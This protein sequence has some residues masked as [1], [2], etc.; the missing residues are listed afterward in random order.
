[1]TSEAITLE[2][3]V[4]RSEGLVSADVGDEVVMLHL[5]KNAYYDTDPV[6]AYIWRRLTEP[7][8]VRE[9]R[10]DLLQ[11]YEVS[12]ETCEADVLAFLRE[13]HR[14]GVIRLVDSGVE[15]PGA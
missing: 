4:V 15:Q 9:L 13:A 14:E 5:E 1:M 11:R 6:G 8:R 2:T 10:D 7:V 3:S 12:P